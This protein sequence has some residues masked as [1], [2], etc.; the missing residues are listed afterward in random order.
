MKKVFTFLLLITMFMGLEV[1]NSNSQDSHNAVLEY[2][3]GTWCQ[4]CPC[5]HDIIQGILSNY[6]KTVILAYHG[7]GNDPWQSYSAGIRS[8]FGFTNYP[9][10]V[11]GRR[12]GII[13]NS[14]WNNKVVQQSAMTPGLKIGIAN[15]TY[16]PSTRELSLTANVT[17]L[18][19]LTG[20]YKINFIL[21]ESNLVYPQTGNGSCP[22]NSNYVHHHVVK[23]MINGDLGEDLHTTGTWS[24]GV[25]K[26]K[27]LNYVLPAGF[28]AE[29]CNINAMVYLSEG[30]IGTQSVTMNAEWRTVVDNPTGINN[31][32]TTASS[33]ELSQNYP[34]PF[35]PTTSIKFSV[36]KDG[37]V[38]LKFYDI[39][40]NEVAVYADGFMKAGTYSA[41][42]DGSGLASG[43][44]FYTL[45]TSE[46]SDTKK[47]ILSK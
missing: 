42:F 39:L 14:G 25:V 1:K 33:Y 37:N 30:N 13:S 22:G 9:T 4:W 44:Y 32:G 38:S 40:G 17:A 10:G 45:T 28:V 5:S 21:T 36:P 31:Q 43:I 29:N 47:M 7:A 27:T 34:N 15:K 8:H 23:A 11:V 18:T 46:F 12:T 26:T 16:N 35:N 2:V 41:E 6:P 19:D 24:N 20:V 3:T